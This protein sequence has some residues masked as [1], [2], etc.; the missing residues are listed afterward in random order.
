[1]QSSGFVVWRPRGTLNEK[2]L[3]DVVAA[4]GQLEGQF[5]CAL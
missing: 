4:L 2:E 1:M 3:S 5:G